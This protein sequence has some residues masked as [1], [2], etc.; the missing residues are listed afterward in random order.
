MRRFDSFRPSQAFQ[1]IISSQTVSFRL[2]I[3][4]PFRLLGPL[5]SRALDKLPTL[6]CRRHALNLGSLDVDARCVWRFMG[7]QRHDLRFGET[8]ISELRHAAVAARR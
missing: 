3:T 1:W 2:S 8:S 6:T 4:P 7:R 5:R